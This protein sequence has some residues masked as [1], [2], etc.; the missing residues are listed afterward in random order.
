M[1]A[2]RILVLLLL[3]HQFWHQNCNCCTN[4]GIKNISVGVIVVPM[5]TSRMLVLLL[6]LLHFWHQDCYCCNNAGIKNISVVVIYCTSV[7]HIKLYMSPP[8]IIV[9]VVDFVVIADVDFTS[10]ILNSKAWRL[11]CFHVHCPWTSDELPDRDFVF[12]LYFRSL[13]LS[14]S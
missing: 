7:L 11:T 9:V 12:V 6:L 14:L 8:L 3:L 2:S 13:S 10:G 5:L 1:L 4:V